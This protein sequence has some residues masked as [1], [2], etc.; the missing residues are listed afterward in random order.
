MRD[1]NTAAGRW[2]TARCDSPN[3]SSET[4]TRPGGVSDD[5]IASS[6][7][8]QPR[9]E[10]RVLG[11]YEIIR[12]LGQGGMGIV[13]LG[14]DPALDRCVAIKLLR[15][16]RNDEESRLRFVREARAAAAIQHDHVVTI[17][18]VAN[19]HAEPP[20]FVMPY[21]AGPTLREQLDIDTQFEPARAAQLAVEITRGLSAAHA[22]GLVHRDIKP[23]NVMLDPADERAKIMDFGLVR[24]PDSDGV[25]QT[26]TNA[27]TPEY[28]SPEQINDQALVD[29]RTDVY[30]LGVSLYEMLTGWRPFR[31]TPHMVMQQVLTDEPRAPRKL[32]D[33]IPRD[34]EV[35]CLKTMEKDPGRRYQTAAELRDDLDRWLRGE[36][37]IARPVGPM[38][39][40]LRWRKRQPALANLATALV[41][42][43]AVAISAV[44]VQW[45]R[46]EHHLAEARRQEIQRKVKE[47][48]ATEA[49]QQAAKAV[50]KVEQVSKQAEDA[51]READ[52]ARGQIL[53]VVLQSQIRQ[54][55]RQDNTARKFFEALSAMPIKVIDRHRD[56]PTKSNEVAVAY[57]GLGQMK[58]RAGD[59]H[60]ALAA[61][62][63]ARDRY[64]VL[65]HEQPDNENLKHILATAHRSIGELKEMCDN[66]ADALSSH[67]HAREIQVELV[68]IDAAAP[69]YLLDLANSEIVIGTLQVKLNQTVAAGASHNRGRAVLHRL[70]RASNTTTMRTIGKDLARAHRMLGD[71][72]RLY[73]T[74]KDALAAYAQA[75]ELGRAAHANVRTQVDVLAEL[76]IA[77]NQQGECLLSLDRLEQAAKS[78]REAISLHKL[79]LKRSPPWTEARHWLQRH[80]KNLT[81]VELARGEIATAAEA[82]AAREAL[83]PGDPLAV[84][85]CASDFAHC[86]SQVTGESAASSELRVKVR[87]LTLEA[88]LHAVEVGFDSGQQLKADP[89]FA[90]LRELPEFRH[91]ADSLPKRAA[92]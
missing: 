7:V 11:P 71:G 37:I 74:P 58:W 85:D 21:I 3:L 47:I 8:I 54:D 33:R 66:L 34:L 90:P 16:D 40:L 91:L 39:R 41:L 5:G 6:T 61:Y 20:Y 9:D 12:M 63:E 31:G 56:D 78:L 50:E 32:N 22:V 68:R 55:T 86:L 4:P 10:L 52:Q 60:A 45:R 62:E 72:V 89:A 23:D 73:A 77:L 25:T 38:G 92:Q 26:R 64:L 84:Y 18:S 15:S 76:A 30:S 87:Q 46:A 53:S 36:A 48:E 19:P 1:H 79:A 88:L 43:I 81:Q 49:S 82:I 2:V 67:Q 80:F 13:L 51:S 24:L 44:L 42:V 29:Q 75:I 17:H 28:M 35:I 69:N 65:S 83:M 59:Q 70:E 27:G 14:Y 57:M